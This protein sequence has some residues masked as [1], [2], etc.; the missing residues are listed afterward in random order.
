MRIDYSTQLLYNLPRLIQSLQDRSI[1]LSSFHVQPT[2]NLP[3]GADPELCYALSELDCTVTGWSFWAGDLSDRILTPLRALHNV[4]TTLELHFGQASVTGPTSGLH[5]YLCESPHLL[6]LRAHRT[7]ILI[8]A[9]DLHARGHIFHK[10]YW[11]GAK[12][13]NRLAVDWDKFLSTVD[14]GQ[15]KVWACRKLQTLH[16][17]V[18]SRTEPELE[19][20]S[21]SR[22]VFGYLSR[23]CPELQDLQI[24]TSMQRFRNVSWVY[25]LLDLRLEGGMCLLTRIKHLRILK[26]GFVGRPMVC[27]ARDLTWLLGAGI[28]AGD[29]KEEEIKQQRAVRRSAVESWDAWLKAEQEDDVAW[30]TS[31]DCIL[32]DLEDSTIEPGL[33]EGL[34]EMGMLLDVKLRLDEMDS[35][36]MNGSRCPWLPALRHISLYSSAESALSPKKEFYRLF[37]PSRFDLIRTRH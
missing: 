15:R 11:E 16:I 33:E 12:E 27:R 5:R 28:T 9:M 10:G 3:G 7:A 21:R 32:W 37:P 20:A 19:S 2:S 35:L 29:Q 34:R 13:K 14:F 31:N 1:Q 4:V 23:I 36:T 22:I 8:E 18:H 17:S 25:P 24:S 26:L 6:H 30:R